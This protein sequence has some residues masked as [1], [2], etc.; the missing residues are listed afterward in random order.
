M[1]QR[2]WDTAGRS[3]LAIPS[4][5]DDTISSHAASRSDVLASGQPRRRNRPWTLE[6][7]VLGAAGNHFAAV[8]HKQIGAKAERLFHVVRHK[9]H[10]A[11]IAGQ[12]LAKL[13]LCLPAQMRIERRKRLIKEQGVG[14]DGHASRDCY[15]LPLPA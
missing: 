2:I 7:L 9:Y 4:V 11:V 12:R 8:Q 1:G 5:Y 3:Q 6:E 13:L 14:L 10:C 15:A